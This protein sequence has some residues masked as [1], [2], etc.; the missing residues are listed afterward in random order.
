MNCKSSRYFPDTETDEK[1][2]KKAIEH[3]N[4]AADNDEV[5][6][7]AILT[8]KGSFIASGA[9]ATIGT[10]D[11]TAHAEINTLRE[12][13]EK[14][15]N[16]RMVDTTLY[17]TLEPCIMCMGAIIHARVE[18]LVFGAFDPKTGAAGSVYSIGTDDKLNHNVTIEGGILQEEC[19]Q[20]LKDF[21]KLRRKN[22]KG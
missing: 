21:F 16:Y 1:W 15:G 2:M 22:R 12:A 17:V 18:R 10:N 13:G 7:G 8:H 9:N 3:A 20:L 5:P 11:P 14:L 19:G 6:V 4:L